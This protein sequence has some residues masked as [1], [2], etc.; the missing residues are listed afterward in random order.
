MRLSRLLAAS[1]AALAGGCALAP[2]DYGAADPA[3]HHPVTPLP[4][5]RPVI[6]LALGSGGKRGFAH[7]G[8]LRALE[9]AGIRPQLVVGTSSGAIVGALYASGLRADALYLPP[10]GE[11]ATAYVAQN[12]RKRGEYAVATFKRSVY[13][14]T[15]EGATWKQ[16]AARGKTQ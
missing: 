6:A 11:D 13:L 16:I 9:E 15:D 12:P 10:L 5:E 7:V 14:T 8:V 2:P 3:S 4:D 1:A